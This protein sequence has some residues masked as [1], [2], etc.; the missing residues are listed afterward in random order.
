MFLIIYLLLPSAMKLGQGYIFT[1]VCDS[2]H[3]G[4]MHGCQGGVHRCRGACVVM[5]E[6][7]WVHGCRGGGVHGCRGCAWLWGGTCMVV[8]RGRACMGYDEI[9]SLSGRYASYWNVYLFWFH[10]FNLHSWTTSEIPNLKR[11]TLRFTSLYNSPIWQN[12][13]FQNKNMRLCQL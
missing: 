4:G 3:G 9:W 12:V 8:G 5:G 7:E 11:R 6:G 13:A 1:G 2:V 10:F